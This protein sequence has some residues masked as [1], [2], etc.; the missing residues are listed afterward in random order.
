MAFK[1]KSLQSC[2]SAIGFKC[3]LVGPS[4][5]PGRPQGAGTN[6]CA[7]RPVTQTYPERKQDSP[8]ICRSQ[9]RKVGIPNNGMHP[10]G[11]NKSRASRQA[12][13][14]PE[15]RAWTAEPNTTEQ[16]QPARGNR[17]AKARAIMRNQRQQPM[18]N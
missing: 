17:P 2:D 13:R 16:E 3:G 8:K 18:I 15:A 12:R 5:R 9:V 11:A 7:H 14:A 1:T 6:L 4:L 10:D